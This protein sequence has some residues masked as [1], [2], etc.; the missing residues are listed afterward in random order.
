MRNGTKPKIELA[1]KLFKENANNPTVAK[2]VNRS[3]RT[4]I[5]WRN[6][7]KETGNITFKP[8]GHK[9]KISDNELKNIENSLTKGAEHYGY[10]NDLWT[11]NRIKEIITKT[12]NK[13]LHV[14][15]VSSLMKRMKWSK[16]KPA[17]VST[18]Y[19]PETEQNWIKNDFEFIKKNT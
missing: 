11:L 16:Q 9:S 15:T 1:I 5:R 19:D 13:T 8:F 3:R 12:T 14:R 7:W 4:V 17:K 6:K 2:Q 18:K 10:I